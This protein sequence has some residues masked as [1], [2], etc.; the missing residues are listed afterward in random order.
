[1][2]C[3]CI[4]QTDLPHTSKLF[5]DL[6]YHFDRVEDLY[7]WRPNSLTAIEQAARATQNAFPDDHRAAI[8]SALT[9]LNNGN[10]S[11]E[12]LARPG[13]V[14][15]V[16]GQQVGLFSGPAYTVYKALTAIKIARQ[17]DAKGIPAVPVF[18]L[19]TEDHDLAE[20]D[21]V[22]VF[23]ADHQPVRLA[24]K[25]PA[26]NGTRPVGGVVLEDLP[27][28]D[29]RAALAG[30]P[31]ADEAAALVT[32]AYQPGSTMGAAFAALIREL[33]AP[34]GLLLIDP[35]DPGIRAVAAPFMAEAVLRMPELVEAL[36]A[37]N[38]ALAA[39][40]YHAQVLVDK[41]T[42]LAFLLEDGHR[43]ALKHA[44]GDFATHH[45]KWTAAELSTRAASLSPNALLRPVLQDYL[46][47]TAAYV[48][49]P[50]ELAYLAQ[51]RVLYDKL[52]GR[53]P[54]AFP[55]A[56]FTLRDDRAAKRMRR[57]KLEL[58]GLLTNDQTL[59]AAMSA[60]LVPAE[61]RASL[62]STQQAISL[63]LDSL[64]TDLGGF[65]VSLNGALATSRRKI[66][67]QMGKIAR[68]TASQMMARDEQAAVDAKSLSGLVFP[69][70]HLQERLYSIVPF[71]AR[72]GPGLI[73]EIYD[74]VEIESPD[75]RVLT[76]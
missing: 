70:K 17:L 67:Y 65:D 30:L 55:R 60:Q 49:G 56:G 76:V 9:P 20:V 26:A 6:V 16:T 2:E 15:I 42:S 71:L 29:L 27:L 68:K 5:A 66:E 61:L 3:S 40:G 45:R 47:P 62:A 57:Y 31:F 32:H 11:L 18:W 36:T 54:V 8:V 19:A 50:A 72:F 4:R 58:P 48:G 13:V 52:L 25:H 22:Y 43:I 46:L 74:Q 38:A 33:F 73:Q 23:G 14:A 10:P 59:Q 53:Q 35:M 75:H 12:K 7:P 24:A 41:Q 34:Y 37:R 64:S 69:E 1:M 63:A 44:N 51:S 21:H 39:R 28:A